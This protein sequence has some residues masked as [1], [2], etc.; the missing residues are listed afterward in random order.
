[1]LRSITRWPVIVPPGTKQDLQILHEALFASFG[2][3]WQFLLEHGK[4]LANTYGVNPEELILSKSNSTIVG[5]LAYMNNSSVSCAGTD[6]IFGANDHRRDPFEHL[7]HQLRGIGRSPH[8]G[9]AQFHH[10]PE[11]TTLLFLFSS[12]REDHVPSWSDSPMYEAGYEPRFNQCT[13]S[14]GWY[15]YFLHSSGVLRG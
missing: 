15:V 3:G 10:R 2:D 13:T 1:M 5:E 7:Q 14:V 11:P 6:Q 12:P 8:M 9:Q 4:S